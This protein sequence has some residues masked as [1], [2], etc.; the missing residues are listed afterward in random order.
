MSKLRAI[1]VEEYDRGEGTVTA[2]A[3]LSVGIYPVVRVP[4]SV[5]AYDQRDEA[6]EAVAKWLA[7]KLAAVVS[8]V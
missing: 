7:A 6:D 8:D 4:C 2:F 3:V 5:T 1:Y